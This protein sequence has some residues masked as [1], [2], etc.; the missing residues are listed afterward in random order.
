MRVE[1]VT[2]RSLPLEIFH[3]PAGLLEALGDGP[4]SRHRAGEIPDAS[5]CQSV[6][7]CPGTRRKLHTIAW[8]ELDDPELGLSPAYAALGGIPIWAALDCAV[9]RQPLAWQRT[10]IAAYALIQPSTLEP[11]DDDPTEV[12]RGVLAFRDA[13]P[14]PAP[15]APLHRLGGEPVWVTEE[16]IIACPACREAMS[17]LLQLDT[18]EDLGWRFG[19]QG[20]LFAFVCARCTVVATLIQEP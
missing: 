8:L 6:P 19:D 3:Q 20:A 4:P 17:F 1:P 13:D 7:R 14:F 12:A 9:S 2:V 5:R 15:D 16:R 18:D 10:G 11:F